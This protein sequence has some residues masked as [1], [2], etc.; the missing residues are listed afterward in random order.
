VEVVLWV[1]AVDAVVCAFIGT[2]VRE[3]TPPGSDERH[4][5]GAGFV[6]GFLLGPLGVVTAAL[7]RLSDQVAYFGERALRD[8]PAAP[9]A[10]AAADEN[11]PPAGVPTPDTAVILAADLM[12][13]GGDTILAEG[14][15]VSVTSARKRGG[16]VIVETT[17]GVQYSFYRA[18]P[19]TV[20][21]P[22]TKG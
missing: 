5:G 16:N 1:L 21:G 9:S 12:E 8:D 11:N 6:L 10:S 19:V 2:A 14:K 20:R 7:L 3:W 17:S 18:D 15:F 22:R 4:A 13:Q